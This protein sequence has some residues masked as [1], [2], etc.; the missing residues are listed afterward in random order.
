MY[1]LTMGNY[2]RALSNPPLLK[3][4]CPAPLGKSDQ[5]EV[6]EKLSI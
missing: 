3:A 2:S 5:S 1:V 4:E 6:M